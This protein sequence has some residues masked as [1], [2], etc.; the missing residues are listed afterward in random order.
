MRTETIKW[1]RRMSL[2]AAGNPPSPPELPTA[3]EA[4]QSPTAEPR[5][6]PCW[7]RGQ[8]RVQPGLRHHRR[9]WPGYAREQLGCTDHSGSQLLLF[10]KGSSP[11][12]VLVQSPTPD[13]HTALGGRQHHTHFTDGENCDSERRWDRLKAPRPV[14]GRVRI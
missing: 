5:I 3:R 1:Q 9:G 8:A 6:L 4:T 14:G 10:T 11:S 12:S 7:H 13:P 2:R